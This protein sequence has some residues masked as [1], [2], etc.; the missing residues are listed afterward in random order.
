[1]NKTIV[2]VG[3]TVSLNIHAYGQGFGIFEMSNV[4]TTPDRHIYLDQY[5]TGPKPEGD[6]YKIAIFWGPEGTL[7]ENALT[8]LGDPTGFIVGPGAGQFISDTL[9]TVFDPDAIVGG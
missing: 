2:V 8:Q 4:G 7:D 3:L 6:G 9:R 1:M 5:L